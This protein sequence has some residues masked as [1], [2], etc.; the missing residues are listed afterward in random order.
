MATRM[1]RNSGLSGLGGSLGSAGL[2]SFCQKNCN[3]FGSLRPWTHVV[4]LVV[5]I[6]VQ[7]GQTSN[8]NNPVEAAAS[9]SNTAA[10]VTSDPDSYDPW[11]ES[12][13]PKVVVDYHRGPLRG[14][15]KPKARN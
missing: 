2:G 1:T 7:G 13:R 12:D 8:K 11:K 4:A 14:K 6:V 10:S 15:R 3:L 9:A 5:L